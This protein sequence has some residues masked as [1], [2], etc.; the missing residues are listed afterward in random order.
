M[1]Q[2]DVLI[3]AFVSAVVRE[4]APEAIV[5]FGSRARGDGREDSDTDLLV[6][7]SAA[8]GPGDSRW[9]ELARLWAI[10][11]RLRM[12]VDL[13]L[14]SHSEID[15]WRNVRGH[16]ISRALTEGRHLYGSI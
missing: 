5:L 9:D 1:A 13:V 11:G 2:W 15:R 12:P 6:V 16:L 3:D 4:T 10:A 7:R 8:F 14:Y